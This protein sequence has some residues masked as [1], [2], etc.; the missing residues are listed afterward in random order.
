MPS[1]R[2]LRAADTIGGNCIEVSANDGQRLL[3]DAG[4]PLDAPENEPTTVPDGLNIAS[5]VVAVLLSHIHQ[6]HTGMLK[7][8]PAA[9][10]VYCGKASHVLLDLE[11]AR[12][13]YVK[14]GDKT[15]TC[16]SITT[17]QADKEFRVGPFLITPILIDH[18]AFDAY[19]LLI[20][21]DGKTILYSGDFRLNGRKG[22]LTQKLIDSPP[23]N[24][25]VLIMEGT[26]ILAPDKSTQSEAGLENKFI[27][28]FQQTSGR[29][30]VACAGTNIDRLVTLYRSCL[31]SGR[32]LGVDLYTLLVMRRLASFADIPQLEWENSRLR[33]IVT[34][35][36]LS[37]V[38]KL[39]NPELVAEIKNTGN[40]CSAKALSKNKGKWVILI[41]GSMVGDFAAKNVLVDAEDAWVWSMWRGYYED[42]SSG[43]L[44][45]YFKPCGE[46]EYI[47]TSGHASFQTL[48]D[49]AKAI[50][51]RLL[52]PVHGNEWRKA[53]REFENIRLVE[54]GELVHIDDFVSET[55]GG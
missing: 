29:V 53:S 16:H 2:V 39:G 55:S 24:V 14:P 32:I 35:R 50:N 5:Q 4:R 19:M 8:L 27:K 42:A 41:R 51:P 34:R 25:D 49:F 6:D 40:V 18:S 17:W 1:L 43:L 3:L 46:P 45:D 20:K 37:Y 48:K 23:G 30:F 13:N 33:A 54:N 10:P 21:V 38:G 22:K 11:M 36:M 31:K 28:L 15:T 26:N 7:Q 9:W 47:H 44:R 12:Q 52:I